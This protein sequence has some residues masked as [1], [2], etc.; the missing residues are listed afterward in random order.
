MTKCEQYV[1]TLG[2]GVGKHCREKKT[3]NRFV[4][5]G[6]LSINDITFGSLQRLTLLPQKYDH[7]INDAEIKSFCDLHTTSASVSSQLS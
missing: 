6:G 1:R 4:F 2:L 5:R 3:H 7:H